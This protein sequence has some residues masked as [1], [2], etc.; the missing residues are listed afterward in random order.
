LSGRL[1]STLR[2]HHFWFVGRESR[3]LATPVLN[4]VSHGRLKQQLQRRVWW[5]GSERHQNA[6]LKHQLAEVKRIL[7]QITERKN[8]TMKTKLKPLALGLLALSTLNSQ[9]ATA[10]AQGTAFTYQGRLNSGANPANGNYDLTFSVFGVASGVG[11]V[12]ST[13]TNFTAV[14]NGLFTVTLDFGNQFPGVGRWL[15]I[16]VRTNGGGSFFTLSPRQALTPAPYA[17][18]AGNLTGVV[19]SAGVAGTYASPVTFSSL[20]NSFS[21]NGSGLANVNA[22]TLGGIGATG[23]W[24]TTGNA[25]TIAGPNFLGTTDNQP[26]EIQ[27]N[28]VRALRIE[29]QG[30]AAANLIGGYYQNSA[31]GSQAAA[32]AGGGTSGSPNY[33]LGNYG[34]VGAGHGARAGM[35]SAVVVGAYND[36][37]SQFSFIGSGLANTNLA[38]YSLIGSGSNNLIQTASIFATLGGGRNNLIRSNSQDVTISGGE[39]N[40]VGTN[41]GVATIGG[42]YGNTIAD[43]AGSSTI[44][45]GW[46]NVVLGGAVYSTIGGGYVNTNSGQI[47]TVGGGYDNTSS[48]SVATVGGGEFNTSSGGGATVGGGGYNTSSGYTATVGG[49]YANM[50]SGYAATVGGGEF[51]TSSGSIATV[52]GGYENTSTGQYATVG[53]GLFNQATNDYAT[54]SGGAYNLAGGRYSFAAGQ[55]AQ[56]LHQGS[57]VWA[58]SQNFPF[59]STANDQFLIRAGGGVGINKNNPASALDVNGTARIQGAN[60]WD[61]NNSEGD[62]RVGNDVQRFKIGVA[63]SGS[64][65]GDV[66][67]RAQGGT[68]RVFI[69]TPGGTTFYSNEGQTAG[70]SLAANGTAW[71]VVSDRNV[72]KDFAA[73]N[74][75]QILEKLAAMPITQW[76]YKWETSDVTPHIGPMAQDFKAA[77]YP[78]TDDKSITTQEADGVALAAIQGL[79]RKMDS[80]NANLREELKRRDA[81]NTELKHRLDALEKLFTIKN[82]IEGAQP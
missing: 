69:K 46:A 57:F 30:S 39:Q 5:Q 81:E 24:R 11:Q 36:A 17:I 19:P 7:N 41:A 35:F 44:A 13:V 31:G 70:V 14:S 16:G 22:L 6:E 67:M 66:W 29:P 58:D 10:R 27:A 49:G 12:G 34:F 15:E 74:S 48:G 42:G 77:F 65:A 1:V 79:N 18:T 80:E 75:V 40:S 71:A 62:F 8:Q 26:L 20:A 43:N 9:L 61:V 23:F 55:Q 28:G 68:A 52:G 21:G 72:K 47:A 60:N 78:G 33:V 50:S 73:I 32:I 4:S 56:A 45:G 59:A 2:L 64:G 51:N 25:G 54:V 63:T 53:G 37:S 38:D 76:H 3:I 82:Q